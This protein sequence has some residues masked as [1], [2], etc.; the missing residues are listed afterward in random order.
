MNTNRYIGSSAL[1]LITFLLG[2]SAFCHIQAQSYVATHAIDDRPF[3]IGEELAFKI[4][5]G[6]FTIGK[7]KAAIP[8]DTIYGQAP[9]YHVQVE[10]RTAGL[11]GMFSNTV[12]TFDAI[13]DQ[14]TLKPYVASQNFLE[15]SE[16][17][18]QTNTFSF[19]DHEVT[20]EKMADN[21]QLK[22][23][24]KKYLLEDNAFDILSSYLYLR[25]I[26]FGSL[27]VTDSVMIK[28][29]FGK[30]HWNFGIE[31]GGIETINTLL[32]KIKTH[33][34]YILFPVSSTFPEA[35][36]VMVWTTMDENQLPLKVKAKL[37]FGH[38]TCEL[39]DYKNLRLPYRK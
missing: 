28:V 6:W 29:F 13:I 16:R 30:K 31:Y 3:V 33:K 8:S 37:R 35:K 23:K 5:Y 10:G 17:Q 22:Y 12:D 11:V 32:G 34:F 7:A 2:I 21:Q 18:I 36:S 38:V 25:N 39:D 9:S 1:K 26:D 20:V 15:N 14:E 4:S 27:N 24:P 19:E